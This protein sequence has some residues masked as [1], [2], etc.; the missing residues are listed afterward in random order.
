MR[1]LSEKIDILNPLC[2]FCE[3]RSATR[4]TSS[5]GASLILWRKLWISGAFEPMH[6]SV[7]LMSALPLS[8]QGSSTMQGKDK[9]QTLCYDTEAQT[10]S[11]NGRQKYTRSMNGC[12]HNVIIRGVYRNRYPASFLL[13]TIIIRLITFYNNYRA[14]RCNFVA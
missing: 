12:N 13:K 4:Y 8:Y 11:S 7:L 9:P 3:E 2:C 10:L 6:C 5:H 1:P 14:T